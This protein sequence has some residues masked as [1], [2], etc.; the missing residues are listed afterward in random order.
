MQA[1]VPSVKREVIPVG[2]GRSITVESLSFT[3]DGFGTTECSDPLLIHTNVLKL[4]ANGLCAFCLEQHIDWGRHMNCFGC[5]AAGRYDLD[6]EGVFMVCPACMEIKTIKLLLS[7]WFNVAKNRNFMK[8][9]LDATWYEIE[10]VC[11]E[12]D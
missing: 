1:L 10:Q 7:R 2:Q 12:S 3:V 4:N 9:A 8:F 5:P 6:K 11:Y